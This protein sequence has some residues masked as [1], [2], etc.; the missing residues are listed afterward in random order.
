MNH[1]KTRIN[2]EINIAQEPSNDFVLGRKEK[3]F[4]LNITFFFPLFDLTQGWGLLAARAISWFWK[5]L[6]A[7]TE[8][9]FE[10]HFNLSVN[11][12]CLL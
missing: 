7:G 10:D 6:M 12:F 9:T 1:F 5:L 4:L 11:I 2:S 3:A 8:R